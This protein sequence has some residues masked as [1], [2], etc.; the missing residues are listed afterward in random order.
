VKKLLLFVL[1]LIVSACSTPVKQQVSNE[2]APEKK[3]SDE[4][5][6][7]LQYF[8]GDDIPLGMCMYSHTE[9]RGIFASTACVVVLVETKSNTRRPFYGSKGHWGIE[10]P[11]EKNLVESKLKEP[12]TMTTVNPISDLKMKRK[13]G[14][15][16]EIL[17][18]DFGIAQLLIEITKP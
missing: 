14:N 15:T 18:D 6:L 7:Y 17:R 12:Q 16:V 2:A 3:T 13:Q 4:C 5:L 9:V 11:C 8:K 10:G 1:T